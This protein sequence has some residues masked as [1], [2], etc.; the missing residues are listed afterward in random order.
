MAKKPTYTPA[1]ALPEDPDLRRRFL[2]IVAVLSEQQTVTGAASSLGLS[3]VHFQTI[4]HR[5]IAAIIAEITPKPAGRPAKPPE[6]AALEAENAKLKADLEALQIRT[7]SI[8][9]LLN[10]VGGIASGKTPLPRTRAKK[11]KPE[12]P[13][14]ATARKQAVM[15]MREQGATIEECSAT[16]GIS[17]STVR[18]DLKRRARAT[19]Q[20]KPLDPTKC[21]QVRSIVRATHGLAG[22]QSLSRM[23]GLP[24]RTCAEIKRRERRDLERERKARC[25]QVLLAAPGTVR[26]F[27][28]MHVDTTEGMA[29][30]LVAADAAI[31][32]RTSIVTVPT[33]DAVHVIAALV[34]DFETHGP[35]LVL[36]LDRIA[37]QRTAEVLALLARYEVLPLYGPPRHP[38]Y[39]GQLERQNREHR[40]WHAVL[41]VVTP[42]ELAAAGE[43]MRTSLN[44]LW[45][46][47]T[48]DGWTADQAWRARKPLQ[49]DRRELIRDVERCTS[50]LVT[51]GIELLRAH[52]VATE[53]ALIERGLLT[54]NQGGSC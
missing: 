50:G 36:R 46:R 10:V 19:K 38:Y 33:Y 26:G 40:A 22:A 9:R 11:T 23:S 52:R 49:I 39:Y 27:D 35:P 21:Q 4:L 31:P 14:P 34:A 17:T 54:I 7:E 32:Y 28:A 42:A 41:G 8:E 16:L 12:D 6:Q 47:P 43:A 5:V 44:A 51:S 2:E 37:C 3:R 13:E 45:S 24:R 20:I 53:R 15:E 48:L 25:K 1:P 29:Y 30:W 18:R